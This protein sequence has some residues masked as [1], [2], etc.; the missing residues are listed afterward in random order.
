MIM[1]RLAISL[2]ALLHAAASAGPL[3]LDMGAK[4]DDLQSKSTL[5]ATAPYQYK[6]SKLPSGHPDFNDYR[7]V[8]TPQHGLCRITAWTPPITSSV[9]G[10]ELLSVFDRLHA[11]LT[12][13]YGAGKRYDFLKTGSMWKELNEWMTAL[14]KKERNLAAFWTKQ[15]LPL[16]DNIEGIKLEA[17]AGSNSAGMISLSYE[18]TNGS[19][20][21]NWIRSQNDSVL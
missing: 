13:K 15:D 17:V 20:C 5:V 4:L 3:G 18:F 8:I 16:P 12:T 21:L 10:T 1:R 7:F 2:A 14:L 9:Y 19:E 11:A 6:T